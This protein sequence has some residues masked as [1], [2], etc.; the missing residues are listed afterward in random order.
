[1]KRLFLTVVFLVLT[2]LMNTFAAAEMSKL[3]GAVREFEQR[4]VQAMTGADVAALE[5]II[6]STVTYTH[7]TGLVQGRQQLIDLLVAGDVVYRSIDTENV[8]YR[9]YGSTVVATGK[10]VIQ[11]TVSGNPVTSK[12]RFTVVY[13]G[14]GSEAD[15]IRMVAYQ[16]TAL[17]RLKTEEKQ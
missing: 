14:T 11:L 5:A 16:S 10:Q 3:E 6:D 17:P 4:R 2:G 15:P 13:V 12:S 8:L 9:Q 7:S 1:M